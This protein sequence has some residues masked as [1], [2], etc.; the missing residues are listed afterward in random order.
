MLRPK[1]LTTLRTYTPRL[2]LADL[3]AGITVAMVALPLS[4]AIA[5]ASGAEP[6]RAS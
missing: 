2:F 3:L 5:I 1:I 4:L 6:A